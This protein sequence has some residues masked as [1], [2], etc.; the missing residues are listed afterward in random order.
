MQRDCADSSHPKS[1]SVRARD[2]KTVSSS[3]SP[4]LAKGPGVRADLGYLRNVS[5]AKSLRL[6]YGISMAAG[7]SCKPP[8][9]IIRRYDSMKSFSRPSSTA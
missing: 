2:L 6:L 9:T 8:L 1:L 3:F 5:Y 4:L 7:G